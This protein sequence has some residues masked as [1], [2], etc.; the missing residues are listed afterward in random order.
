MK[1]LF[2]SKRLLFPTDRGGLV[3]TLN[4]VRHLA[5][6][7]ELTF[8]CNQQPGQEQD[9]DEMSRLGVRLE[10]VPWREVSRSDWRFYR[11]LAWNLLSQDPFN[12]AKDYDPELRTRARRLLEEQQYDVVICDFVQMARNAIGIWHGPSVLFEHNVEAEIFERHAQTDPG[13]VRRKFMGYQAAK[14]R[15]FEGWAGR[16]FT[17][18]VAVS[19]R[20]REQYERRYGWKHVDVIDTA[21][22]IDH[23]RPIDCAK[24]PGMVVFVGSLDWLPNVDGLQWFVA[25]VWPLVRRE[26]PEARLR[27]VGRNPNPEIQKL[28]EHS[29]VEVVGPVPDTRPW[30]AE[31]EVSIVPLRIGGGTR[32]KV[33]E[34][35]AMGLPVASTPLGAEGLQV[36]SGVNLMLAEGAD[37]LAESVVQLLRSPQLRRTLGEAARNLVET[38]FSSESVARQFES[39]CRRAVEEHCRK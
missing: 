38:Q 30:L 21:V 12:A 25:D 13:W 22:D 29:G 32:L 34:A 39:I 6:W 19:E 1:I 26:H 7:H 11:D 35:M 18:V 8:L 37:R 16:Q 9:C 4:V 31:A 2:L 36:E 28:A 33:F 15:R 27:L 17:R 5:R 14:M 20:D 23:Y 24:L 3:R 10:T